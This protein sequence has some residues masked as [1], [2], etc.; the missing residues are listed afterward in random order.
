VDVRANVAEFFFR[1]TLLLT[2]A[3][4]TATLGRATQIILEVNQVDHSTMIEKEELL[5]RVIDLWQSTQA[6]ENMTNKD[7]TCKIC[8]DAPSDCV[9]LE[10][11]KFLPPSLPATTRV[12]SAQS[13]VQC[14]R[15]CGLCHSLCGVGGPQAISSRASHAVRNLR[16][17]QCAAVQSFGRSACSRR[18]L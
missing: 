4:D 15:V 3:P 16:N 12:R 6:V 18:S 14:C 10:C 11:G 9:F 8:M 13:T 1:P 5:S 2:H 17:A 7:R